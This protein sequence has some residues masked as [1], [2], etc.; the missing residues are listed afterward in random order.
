MRDVH[1]KPSRLKLL[2][3]LQLSI[4]DSSVLN[5]SLMCAR[6]FKC[7]TQKH[8]NHHIVFQPQMTFFSGS[9]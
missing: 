6:A 4:S 1:L 9:V 8:M 7:D 2:L 5:V 3:I